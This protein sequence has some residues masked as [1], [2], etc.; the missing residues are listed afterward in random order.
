M[1][2]AVRPGY[3]LNVTIWNA[4]RSEAVC[5]LF[6]CTWPANSPFLFVCIIFCTAIL[7]N[8]LRD[9]FFFCLSRSGQ[10][11]INVKVC[12]VYQILFHYHFCYQNSPF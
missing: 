6:Y 12:T 3:S 5:F 10:N 1:W 8:I 7:I 2:K 9:E 4:A 11:S